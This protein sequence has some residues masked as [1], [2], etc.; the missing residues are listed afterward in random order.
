M[1][2]LVARPAA[3][4][5]LQVGVWVGA[6]LGATALARARWGHRIEAWLARH[7]RLGPVVGALL[8]VSPGCG[9]AIV[10]APLYLR[11][12]VSFGAVVATLTATMGDS[13]FVLLSTAP[14]T[15][16]ALHA[17]LLVVG[18]VTGALVDLAGI[19]PR[20][21]RRPSVEPTRRPD[22]GVGTRRAST[23]GAAAGVADL[24]GGLLVRFPSPALLGFWTLL[25]IGFALSVPLTLAGTDPGSLTAAG[26]DLPL[27]V[28]AVGAAACVAVTT[29]GRRRRGRRG[30]GRA[31]VPPV[32]ACGRPPTALR[33]ALL[34]AARETAFVT[35]WVT[36]AFVAWALALAATG[37][38][39][40][41]LATGGLVG[42]AVG[43]A[44]GLVPGCGPQILVTGLYA[45]GAIGFPVLVANALSQDGDALFPMLAYDRRSALWVT[46]LTTVPALLVGAALTAAGG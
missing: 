34:D 33:P 21:R 5:F 42:V 20:T 37:W 3:D 40:A 36:V 35:T 26:V 12:D 16:I 19:D 23:V 6:M 24:A 29:A 8:G 18:A 15:A 30:S 1:T 14:R 9:G 13:S 25:A 27:V 17:L 44:V 39:P 2:D 43:A 22:P 28:G 4:A 41:A 7:R 45:Q 32:G 38:D 31:A 46:G 10:V 11:G